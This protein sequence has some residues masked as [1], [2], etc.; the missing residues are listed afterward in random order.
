[1]YLS[2]FQHPALTSA[3]EGKKFVDKA[4]GRLGRGKSKPSLFSSL[5]CWRHLS[6]KSVITRHELVIFGE[7]DSSSDIKVSMSS[8]LSNLIREGLCQGRQSRVCLV[9]AQN[10]VPSCFAHLIHLSGYAITFLTPR[11]H[12]PPSPTLQ[13][14]AIPASISIP[15]SWS[16]SIAF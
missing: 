8:E 4:D 1:M 9:R 3:K 15:G 2:R 11:N 13:N 7:V 6:I 16:A 10:G 14:I 12:L 5:L